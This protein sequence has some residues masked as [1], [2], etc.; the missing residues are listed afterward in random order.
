[1]QLE[2][3]YPTHFQ[4]TYKMMVFVEYYCKV[5][6]FIDK[7]VFY[8]EQSKLEEYNDRVMFW[9]EQL[10]RPVGKNSCKDQLERPVGKTSW[11]EYYENKYKMKFLQNII[12]R[13]SYSQI[14]KYFIENN[15]KQNSIIRL[16]WNFF[17]YFYNFQHLAKP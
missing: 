1:M 6:L 14:K 7:K 8:R 15:R 5:L 13:F 12:A 11:K 4:M 17:F 16:W 3:H 10:Q 2:I 9:K